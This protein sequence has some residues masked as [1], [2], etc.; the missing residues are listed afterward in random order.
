MRLSISCVASEKPFCMP[1]AEA[2]NCEDALYLYFRCA[3]F[4]E[5]VFY[6]SGSLAL[7]QTSDFCMVEMSG[8]EP[9]T[10]CLQGRCSPN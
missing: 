9:L 7:Y 3:V 10:P 6:I 5:Q 4:K 8:F 1:L 2:H